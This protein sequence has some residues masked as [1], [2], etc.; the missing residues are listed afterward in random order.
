MCVYVINTIVPGIVSDIMI[1]LLNDTSIIVSWNEPLMKNG[2]IM[3]YD[4]RL[5]HTTRGNDSS[6]TQYTTDG[7]MVEVVIG[8]SLHSVKYTVSIRA[9]TSIGPG[10]WV[11]MEYIRLTGQYT[12]MYERGMTCVYYMY[13]RDQQCIIE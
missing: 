6:S 4:I 7:N 13:Y 5:N 12:C 1:N 10:D 3:F 11:S 8:L 9:H 2:H